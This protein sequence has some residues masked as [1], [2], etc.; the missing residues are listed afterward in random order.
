VATLLEVALDEPG[1][2][3]ALHLAVKLVRHRASQPAPAAPPVAGASP[4]VAAAST[5]AP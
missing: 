1:H 3:L 4:R 2:T 5:V